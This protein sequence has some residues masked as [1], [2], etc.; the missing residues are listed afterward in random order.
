MLRLAGDGY[1]FVR[2]SFK[3]GEYGE[4]YMS[5]Q[6]DPDML[7][8]MLPGAVTFAWDDGEIRTIPAPPGTLADLK[9]AW[10]WIDPT[11]RDLEQEKGKP[12]KLC[13]RLDSGQFR[14]L[15]FPDWKP[16]MD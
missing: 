6:W 7:A 4:K 12:R 10:A 11:L 13:F 1:V 15:N 5:Q 9:S 8:K 16:G 2:M 14:G 3:S